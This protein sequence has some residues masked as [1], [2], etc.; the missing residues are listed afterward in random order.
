MAFSFLLIVSSGIL[1]IATVLAFAASQHMQ[2]PG[3]IIIGFS[4]LIMALSS[5]LMYLAPILEFSPS[6]TNTIL[7]IFF[8]AFTGCTASSVILTVKLFREVHFYQYIL[9]IFKDVDRAICSKMELKNLITLFSR[10]VNRFFNSDTISVFQIDPETKQL[11]NLAANDTGKSSANGSTIKKIDGFSDWVFKNRKLLA[12]HDV[13]NDPRLTGNGPFKEEG[14]RSYLGAPVIIKGKPVGVV[15]LVSKKSRH[16]SSLDT[17]LFSIFTDQLAIAI[18]NDQ[19]YEDLHRLYDETINSLIQAIETRDP[20]TKGHSQQVAMITNSIARKLG[21][22]EYQLTLIT[23]AGLL[24]DIGKIGVDRKIIH[25]AG[26]LDE[27]EW[28]EMKKHPLESAKI[29]NNIGQLKSIVPWILHHHERWDG[30]GYNGGLREETIPLE[31]RILAIADTFSAMTSDRPYRKAMSFDDAVTEIGFVTGK[32][33]DPKVVEVF[34][35]IIP[36]EEARVTSSP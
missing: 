31:A 1:F 27:E 5:V 6:I 3:W 28:A 10:K 26:P 34:M 14:I 16:F 7:S 11:E 33:F 9:D 24:H 12:V 29:I 17:H 25:K 36:R 32:Q 21:F 15:S 35:A 30:K 18:S 19:Y 13:M 22:D 23:Y 20:Y 4:L 2:R 8:L